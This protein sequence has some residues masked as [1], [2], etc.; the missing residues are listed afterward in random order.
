MTRKFTGYHM[1]GLCGA[2]FGTVVTVNMVMAVQASRT[3]GGTVVDNSYV[4]SQHFNRWLDEARV[5]RRLGWTG[6]VARQ[7]DGRVSL[8][9]WNPGGALDGAAVTAVAEHPLGRSPDRLL[10]F[11]PI[12]K[13]YYRTVEPLPAGRWRLRLDIRAPIGRTRLIRDVPA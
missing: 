4:A 13:G 11:T 3:F 5:A 12:G 9:L 6:E 2:F 8:S 1:L 7:R 10:R